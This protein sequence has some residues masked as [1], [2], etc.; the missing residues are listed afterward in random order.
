MAD[1][2]LCRDCSK[3]I[4]ATRNN[5]YRTHKDRYGEPCKASSA[6]IPADLLEQD[7]ADPKASADTPVRGQDFEVCPECRRNVKLTRLGYFQPHNPTLYGGD[8]CKTS[9]VRAFHSGKTKDVPLPGDTVPEKGVVRATMPEVTNQQEIE[10]ALVEPA[11]DTVETSVPGPDVTVNRWGEPEYPE[12]DWP[13]GL[14]LEMDL[15]LV[16][17][18]S[19]EKILPESA[20][21]A[22]SSASTETSSPGSATISTLSQE[23]TEVWDSYFLLSAHLILMDALGEPET[24]APVTSA[25]PDPPQGEFDDLLFT[26]RGG[27]PSKAKGPA[28]PMTPLGLAMAERIKETFY[29]YQNRKTKDNRSAQTTLGPSEIGTPCDRRLA[30]ALMDIP[31]VNAGG[32]GWAAFVGTCT[33]TGMAEVY[34]FADAGTGRYAVEM[35][36]FLGMPS[37]PRGTTDLLDRRDGTITDWKV[38]GANSLRTFKAEGPSDS[39]RVQAHVYGLGAER[40]GEEVANVAIVGL[41]RAGASLNGMHVWTEKFNRKLAEDA[42]NRVE[43]IAQR[44]AMEYDQS[45]MGRAKEF[46]TGDDCTFCQ[47]H[48]KNDKEMQ[49]GCP[50]Q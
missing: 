42:L 12:E 18:S 21:S 14:K 25:T 27:Y 44:V 47:F 23:W 43:Q 9:G 16:G 17:S 3:V 8:R 48:L 50:G 20:P 22:G 49:R 38:M 15:P 41:P 26:S 32:D 4:T 34:T 33:H 1:A 37:V 5:R 24:P 46:E 31:A 45:P 7:P 36:V 28:Q 2:Y 19:S 29:A 13:D 11:P 35:P 40:G 10:A 39:Y 30:M 6:E